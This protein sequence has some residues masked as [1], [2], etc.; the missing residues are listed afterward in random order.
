MAS[1]VKKIIATLLHLGQS[2]VIFLLIYGFKKAILETMKDLLLHK[3][4]TQH[5]LENCD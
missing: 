2:V 1:L 4:V 3:S 5:T